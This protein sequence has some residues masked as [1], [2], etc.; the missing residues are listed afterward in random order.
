MTAEKM[1]PPHAPRPNGRRAL[2]RPSRRVRGAPPLSRVRHPRRRLRP[3]LPAELRH[4]RPRAPRPG[5][6][7][8]A[9]RTCPRV[10]CGPSATRRPTSRSSPER[11]CLECFSSARP[12]AAATTVGASHVETYRTCGARGV[13][14]DDVEKMDGHVPMQSNDRFSVGTVDVVE[15]LMAM[16]W[17]VVVHTVQEG[18]ARSPLRCP[19]TPRRT[20]GTRVRCSTASPRPTR[21]GTGGETSGTPPT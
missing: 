15:E 5:L 2:A 14:T 19:T 18:G 17:D 20:P 8:V 10:L 1:F 9:C 3:R 6:R 11:T 16:H 13:H 4:R 7:L 12:R 21:E